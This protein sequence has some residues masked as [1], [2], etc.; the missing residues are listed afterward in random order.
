MENNLFQLA[1]FFRVI[2]NKE[3]V[4]E[5]TLSSRP[6]RAVAVTPVSVP[7]AMAR[8]EQCREELGYGRMPTLERGGPDVGGFSPD[9]KPGDLQL[10][11]RLPPCFSHKAWVFSVL[12]G[13]SSHARTVEAPP[14]EVPAGCRRCQAAWT[15]QPRSALPRRALGP[16]CLL[17]VSSGTL[18][19]FTV[20]CGAGP[21]G[22]WAPAAR[23]PS[24]SAQPRA[25]ADRLQ[26]HALC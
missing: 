11:S 7:S 16:T 17:A 3:V 9:A 22:L 6:S 13:V 18:S 21:A 2:R 24:G 20:I 26:G 14:C 12:T 4:A 19:P 10:S 5:V 8:E 25:H 23:C 1:L 15:K